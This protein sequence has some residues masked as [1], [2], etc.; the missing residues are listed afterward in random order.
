MNE[1]HKPPKRIT[2][3]D[4]PPLPGS[5]PTKAQHDARVADKGRPWTEDPIGAYSRPL[6]QE[7][8]Q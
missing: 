5:P 1:R 8:D 2:E 7:D 4:A 3:V 6:Q